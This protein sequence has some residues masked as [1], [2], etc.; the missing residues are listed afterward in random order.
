MEKKNLGSILPNSFFVIPDY[1]RGYAWGLSQLDDL[2]R[3]LSWVKNGGNHYTGSLTLKP[4]KAAKYFN[5]KM[6]CSVFEVVD[7]QQRLTTLF[8]LINQIIVASNKIN[9]K[10]RLIGRKLDKIKDDF[11]ERDFGEGGMPTISYQDDDKN[12]LLKSLVDTGIEYFGK[13]NSHTKK[14]SM[15]RGYFRTN[16]RK[17]SGEELDKLFHDVVQKLQFNIIYVDEDFDACAMFESINFRGKPLTKFEVLKNRLIYLL[18]MIGRNNFD[19]KIKLDVV[20]A[21]INSTWG[22]VYNILGVGDELLSEDNFLAVHCDVYFGFKKSYEEFLLREY[23]SIDKVNI[24]GC[25]DDF[26]RR[27]SEYVSS[28]RFSVDF[29]AYQR[30]LSYDFD[31]RW[32]SCGDVSNALGRLNLLDIGHFN[33]M[34]LG[35][36]IKIGSKEVD[37][38][39][40]PDVWIKNFSKLLWN[41]ERFVFINYKL[42]GARSNHRAKGIFKNHGNLFYKDEEQFAS[43]N[44][45]LLKVSSE[46][47]GSPGNCKKLHEKISEKSKARFHGGR[48]WVGFGAIKYFALT[49][50]IAND[51]I[52]NNLGFGY[53]CNNTDCITLD[54]DD[55]SWNEEDKYLKIDIGN[56]F[57]SSDRIWMDDKEVTCKG[58][59][60]DRSAELIRFMFIHWDIPRVNDNN[61]SSS[62][63]DQFTSASIEMSDSSVLNS[64]EDQDD[65]Q[66]DWSFE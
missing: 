65:D 59:V 7:G 42:I 50:Y 2:W 32:W 31:T 55:F 60:I 45:L 5:I 10:E 63:I 22:Y 24:D 41:I 8:L 12:N 3:D 16:L 28:V 17:Y 66:E 29:W 9:G 38:V 15:A 46:D 40:R 23:F 44:K 13:K 34:V 62:G 26:L 6:S 1:Q 30:G 35:A 25:N 33:S 49:Y 51:I 52:S 61:L 21:S 20:R 64:S 18:E 4:V 56:I 57:I 53:I 19:V 48:G 58:D 39:Q 36:L 37:D 43:A 14:I 54:Y 27:I 47:F 11:I